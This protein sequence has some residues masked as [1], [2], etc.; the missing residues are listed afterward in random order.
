MFNK[1]S[2]ITSLLFFLLG[3]NVFADT[4]LKVSS[5]QNIPVLSQITQI[6]T[7]PSD[8]N[9]I[10]AANKKSKTQAEQALLPSKQ[11]KEAAPSFKNYFIP[12]LVGILFIVGFGSYWMI[13]RRRFT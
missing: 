4:Q 6:N 13:F 9:K 10:A 5:P 12:S 2:L 11:V 7:V 1:I 8:K 3:T